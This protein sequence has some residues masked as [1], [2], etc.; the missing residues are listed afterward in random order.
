M[1]NEDA[2]R[3]FEEQLVRCYHPVYRY[4]VA[5]IPDRVNAEDVF[6]ETCLTILRRWREYDQSR[7][8]MPW[9]CGVALNQVRAFYKRS[10]HHAAF[11]S[12]AAIASVSEAQ[13][14]L[15]AQT[16]RRLQDLRDCLHKLSSE[17]RRCCGNATST[18]ARSRPSPKPGRWIP[19]CCT[20]GWRRPPHPLRVHRGCRGCGGK[21]MNTNQ[22]PPTPGA[23]GMLAANVRHV[24]W[25]VVTGRA[26]PA[27]R[28]PVGRRRGPAR[29]RPLYVDAR[30][31]D[32]VSFRRRGGRRRGG[33]GVGAAGRGTARAA[34]VGGF[35]I[36]ELGL[37]CEPGGPDFLRVVGVA[38]S[39]L[40]RRRP[41]VDPQS[42]SATL[43]P[44][45]RCAAVGRAGAAAASEPTITGEPKPDPYSH[46]DL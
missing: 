46:S 12:E 42:A 11:L 20:S 10:R 44:R 2:R 29:V 8:I 27:R 23:V 16:D 45:R 32:V 30:R 31:P 26:G 19:T 18:E 3:Y 43:R 22:V 34:V 28:D 1:E 9:V 15:T 39:D 21:P 14:R 35:G 24:Q 38:D 17:Q 13:H 4:I 33:A 25:H 37:L 7:P 5:M 6:Q 36:A 40:H 41:G